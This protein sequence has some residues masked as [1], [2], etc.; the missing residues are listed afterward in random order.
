MPLR[1]LGPVLVAT[2]ATSLLVVP[3]AAHASALSTLLSGKKSTAT[4]T[5]TTKNADGKTTAIVTTANPTATTTNDQLSGAVPAPSNCKALPTTKAFQ[6]VDGDASDYSLAPGGDFE[7]GTAGWTLASGARIVNGNETLGVSSGSKALQMP[8][9]STATS[10]EFC[11][12]QS[13]PHFRFAF[14][15]DN[16]ALT[17]FVA[18]VIYRDATGHIT[19]IE[20]VS[21]KTISLRP[22]AWQASP[23][24]PLATLIPLNSTNRS[25]TVQLKLLSFSPTDAVNDVATA[26]LGDNKLVN[27]VTKT[28][29]SAANLVASITG[30]LAATTGIATNIG[31]TVD[32][33]MVDP[34]RTR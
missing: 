4:T 7:S 12:D 15:V 20:L 8:L 30:G 31:V 29:G 32:S 3:G 24:S 19:N 9:G 6:G 33:V 34:Y 17:G 1:K 23:L 11:V 28:G 26:V 5:T 10:P 22:T 21:S 13:N 2:A 14:K 27:S 18:Y 16:A 25:A